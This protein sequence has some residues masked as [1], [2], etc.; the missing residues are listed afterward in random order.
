MCTQFK[1]CIAQRIQESPNQITD[2][3]GKNHLVLMFNIF[4]RTYIKWIEFL[5]RWGRMIS[6]RIDFNIENCSLNKFKIKPMSPLYNALCT[7]QL[8][9][10][11][12][13]VFAR[14]PYFYFSFVLSF[15]SISGFP[16]FKY[17]N[18]SLSKSLLM[19]KYKS[20]PSIFFYKSA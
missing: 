20:F 16:S 13:L 7:L 8:W 14:N 5:K 15:I 3:Y 9:L 19:S 18:R 17:L 11:K 4:R 12:D 10:I 1:Y 2:W 6:L